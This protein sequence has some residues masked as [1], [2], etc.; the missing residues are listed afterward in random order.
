MRN[1][2]LVVAG[3]ATLRAGLARL[4]RNAGYGVELAE[5]TAHARRIGIKGFP[6]AVVAPEGRGLG[7]AWC[8]DRLAGWCRSAE[9]DG[10]A[11]PC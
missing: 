1:R 11:L 10:S 5:S 8:M 6:V 7:A 4:I 2:I 3:D 9:W